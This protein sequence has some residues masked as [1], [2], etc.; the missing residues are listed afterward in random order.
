MG[1]AVTLIT[2]YVGGYGPAEVTSTSMRTL[3]ALLD[4]NKPFRLGCL[5]LSLSF[6][7]S[8][9]KRARIVRTDVALSGKPGKSRIPA[10]FQRP[11]RLS[12]ALLLG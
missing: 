5:P 4:L 11:Q 7:Y 12:P 2:G 1:R 8:G 9:P 10:A 6:L 3:A